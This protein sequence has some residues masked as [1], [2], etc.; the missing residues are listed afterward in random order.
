[1]L[2]RAVLEAMRFKPIWI[3]PWRYA[4]RDAVI[5][6]GTRRER[7]VRQGTVVMPATL[8][9]MFDPDAVERPN[10][11]DVKRSRRDYLVYG[12][13][14]H[15]C[16]G[17]EVARVQI[18]E[19]LRALFRKKG[20]RRTAGRA[21]R[22]LRVGAFPESLKVDF[23]RDPALPCRR[24]RDGRPSSARSAAK[25]S[26]D[27]LRGQISALGNPAGADVPRRSRR[28]AAS[29]I[30]PACGLGAAKREQSG[31]RRAL[32]LELSGDGTA[33]EVIDAFAIMP[34]RSS[35]RSSK[36]ACDFRPASNAQGILRSRNVDISPSFGAS[37]GLVFSG[38]PGLSVARIRAE[39][40]LAEMARKIVEK[41]RPG[42]S[43]TPA[44]VLAEVREHVES[45]RTPRL[46]CWSRRK[47]CWTSRKGSVWR[48]IATTLMAPPVLGTAAVVLLGLLVAT[49]RWFSVPCAR[50]F[51]L[52]VSSA[53]RPRC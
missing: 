7:L 2:D 14:I 26:P 13:G 1:M 16:I 48:A 12:H 52:P 28:R 45:Y 21:G 51:P 41:P 53:A 33:E 5:A 25:P 27:D 18:G 9:A 35:S 20:V 40:E 22:L 4:A 23:E 47:T 37:A 11:F 30:S 43:A 10:E 24:A 17:A 8:S 44:E 42:K 38:T 3:G 50:L 32:L 31:G 46:G 39:A 49:Y 36:Q 19:C 29:S 34:A 15:L 6:R